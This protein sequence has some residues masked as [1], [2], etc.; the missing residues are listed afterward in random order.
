MVKRSAAAMATPECGENAPSYR[1]VEEC[2]AAAAAALGAEGISV[3]ADCATRAR[4][5]LKGAGPFCL[6]SGKLAL[7]NAILHD[8]L[9]AWEAL[10]AAEGVDARPQAGTLEGADADA[11]QRTRQLLDA[12]DADIAECRRKLADKDA[13]LSVPRTEAAAR[14]A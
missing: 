12:K 9:A 2:C 3:P 10:T 7:H 11:L 14:R 8:R 1:S 4:E 13:K 6:L 5:L